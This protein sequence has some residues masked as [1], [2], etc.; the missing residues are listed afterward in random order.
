MIDARIIAVQGVGYAPYAMGLQGVLTIQKRAPAALDGGGPDEDPA[1]DWRYGLHPALRRTGDPAA[2]LIAHLRAQ[3]SRP[4][5]GA[6]ELDRQEAKLARKFKV[7]DPQG[8]V[9]VP[10]FRPMIAETPADLAAKAR[11]FAAQ[12]QAEINDE[13][14]RILLLLSE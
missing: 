6:T 14:L 2:D 1:Y 13:R 8:A 7:V 4:P 5:Q 11:E 3:A 10:L 9:D 12:V